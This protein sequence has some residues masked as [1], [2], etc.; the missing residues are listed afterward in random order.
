MAVTVC[1]NGNDAFPWP[2][3]GAVTAGALAVGKGAGVSG[4]AIGAAWGRVTGGAGT[5]GLTATSRERG[6]RIAGGATPTKVR[7]VAACLG[8]APPTCGG[9]FLP[10]DMM[11]PDDSTTMR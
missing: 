11:P 9:W 2:E 8:G 4:R 3:R 7:F 5:D 1:A 6:G 10:C